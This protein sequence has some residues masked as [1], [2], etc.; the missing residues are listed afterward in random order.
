MV[1]AFYLAMMWL[2]VRNEIGEPIEWAMWTS[3]CNECLWWPY[4]WTSSNFNGTSTISSFFRVSFSFQFI[5]NEY[6]TFNLIFNIWFPY[7][8]R[9]IWINNLQL[10]ANIM[11]NEVKSNYL[12]VVSFGI[13]NWNRFGR[14]TFQRGMEMGSATN[15]NATK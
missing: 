9:Q 8:S 7:D 12:F 3:K 2:V 13:L 4:S 11:P 6:D 5:Q 14:Y 1:T 10:V 15:M